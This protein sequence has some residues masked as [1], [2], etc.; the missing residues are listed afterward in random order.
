MTKRYFIKRLGL[1]TTTAVL[2]PTI[3]AEQSQLA[4]TE[5]VEQMRIYSSGKVG[6]SNTQP[7]TK[8]DIKL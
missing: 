3:I 1:L 2:S 8:I 4:T 6:M 7:N 5:P